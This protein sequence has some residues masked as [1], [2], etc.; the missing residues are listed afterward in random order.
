MKRKKKLKH[1]FRAY[2]PPSKKDKT[3]RPSVMPPNRPRP[4]NRPHASWR[5][6]KWQRLN[7]L[8]YPAKIRGDGENAC[9]G[10]RRHP[11]PKVVLPN[12]PRR[13]PLLPRAPRSIR[14]KLE[15]RPKWR[16]RRRNACQTVVYGLFGAIVVVKSSPS[17]PCRVRRRTT[18]MKRAVL[19]IRPEAVRDEED[20]DIMVGEVVGM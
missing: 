13:N 3:S 5:V 15:R 2:R 14:L 17:R 4:N 10:H 11:H 20:D 8:T 7:H 18:R 16:H 19:V 12:Q 9:R 6:P 1:P